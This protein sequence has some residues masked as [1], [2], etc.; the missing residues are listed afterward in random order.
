[1]IGFD[2]KGRPKLSYRCVDQETGEDISDQIADLQNDSSDSNK[3]DRRK[4][5]SR[6]RDDRKSDKEDK[7]KKKRGFF[8]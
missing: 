6:D 1:M 7:P 4:K 8:S 2:K 3:S 5:P